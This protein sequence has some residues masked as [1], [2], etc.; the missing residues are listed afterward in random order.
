MTV[1]LSQLSRGGDALGDA[2]ATGEETQRRTSPPLLSRPEG[3]GGDGGRFWALAGE[4]SEEED[5]SEEE[6]EATTPLGGRSGP[7]P[8][9]LGD[10]FVPD[11]VSVCRKTKSRGKA[12]AAKGCLCPW[13][14]WFGVWRQ[15][16]AAGDGDF[17]SFA[18]QR[19]C[20]AALG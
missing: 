18:G 2:T 4:S 3:T 9:T 20:H 6:P 7:S 12:R 8:V 17:A 10:F 19:N 14:P 16:A 11:W 1:S 13:W 15:S 5:T